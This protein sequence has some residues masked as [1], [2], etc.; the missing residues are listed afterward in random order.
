MVDWDQVH[1]SNFKEK[2]SKNL[3]DEEDYPDY[4][5]ID[6]DTPDYD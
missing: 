4:T 2:I 6:E 3:N 5:S 1:S